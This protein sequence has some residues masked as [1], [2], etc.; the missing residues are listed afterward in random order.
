MENYC[1]MGYSDNFKNVSKRIIFTYNCCEEIYIRCH[2]IDD[3]YI[4]GKIEELLNQF[5]T[6]NI[7][8]NVQYIVD[9]FI[10]K[11]YYMSESDFVRLRRQINSLM[12]TQEYIDESKIWKELYKNANN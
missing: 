11:M 6:H 2:P 8:Y 7:N 5:E 1:K 10:N 9:S 4:V 3:E 12:L